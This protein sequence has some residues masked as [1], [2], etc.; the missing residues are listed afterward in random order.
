[1]LNVQGKVISGNQL[2]ED[3]R[4]K[5][6]TAS[7]N[8][9]NNKARNYNDIVGKKYEDMARKSNIPSDLLQL[10]FAFED[11]TN[12]IDWSNALD[13]NSLTGMSWEDL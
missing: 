9:Y 3:S 5:L 13:I 2:T 4:Q 8:L 12:K 6:L 1:M 11:S 10:N 7:L